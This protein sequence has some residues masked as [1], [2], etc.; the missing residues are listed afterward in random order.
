MASHTLKLIYDG[1][2]ATQHRMPPSLE[3]QITAGAQELLGSHAYFFTEGR[4]PASVQDRSR[5]FQL[6]D[7]RQKD[8]SW[9]AHYLIDLFADEYIRNLTKDAARIAATA[10]E[11]AFASLIYMSIEAWR[12]RRISKET[13]FERIEPVLMFS[14]GNREPIV[15]LE[16]EREWQRR[17]LFDRTDSSMSKMTAPIGRAASHLDLWIDQTHLSRVERRFYQED[18]I[19]HAVMQFRATGRP[20]RIS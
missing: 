4:I 10:T 17:V 1:L 3:K 6:H 2:G 8:G 20:N 15:D 7:L 5:H 14:N 16:S 11:A 18:E 13:A 19:T 12:T 9:E